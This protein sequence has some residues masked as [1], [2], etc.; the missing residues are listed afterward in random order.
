[1]YCTAQ[2][3]VLLMTASNALPPLLGLP[4]TTWAGALLAAAG[5]LIAVIPVKGFAR[6]PA[7]PA[8][9]VREGAR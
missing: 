5:M 7:T 8:K 3:G 6:T 4:A 2:G 9:P 1:A